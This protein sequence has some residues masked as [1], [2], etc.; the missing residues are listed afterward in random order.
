MDEITSVLKWFNLTSL[1]LH[2]TW[3]IGG[4][5]HQ[6]VYDKLLS[7]HILEAKIES[8]VISIFVLLGSAANALYKHFWTPNF[9]DWTP[10]F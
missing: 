1:G 3:Q 6:H 4:R 9:G 7:A 2:S 5:Y 10:K 8:E